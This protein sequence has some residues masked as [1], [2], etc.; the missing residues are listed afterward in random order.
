M[1]I[2]QENLDKLETDQWRLCDIITGDETWV[3]HRATDSEQSNMTWCADSASPTT[4]IR[5]G[6]HDCKNMLMIFFRTTELDFIH[7]I[8]SGN[9]I[10]GGYYKNNCLKPLFSSIRRKR[11]N[12][13]LRGVRLHDNNARC[14]DFF[15]KKK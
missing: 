11:F 15:K 12:D 8:E 1:K 14:H 9:S 3:Y 7:M 13:G 2:C 5:R 10:T 4:M 6:Q